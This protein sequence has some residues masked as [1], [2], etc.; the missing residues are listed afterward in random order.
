MQTDI[1]LLFEDFTDWLVGLGFLK[2]AQNIAQ[3]GLT[4]LP[5]SQMQC[6]D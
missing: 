1:L 6:Q 5:V 3:T 4:L 2:Q